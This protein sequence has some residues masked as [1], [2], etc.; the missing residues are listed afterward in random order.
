MRVDPKKIMK[1]ARCIENGVP[2]KDVLDQGEVEQ[3]VLAMADVLFCLGKPHY[4]PE[5]E[6]EA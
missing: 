4:N 2:L 5:W 6:Q 1:A 3:V